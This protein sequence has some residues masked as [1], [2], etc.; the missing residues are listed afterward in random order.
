MKR[1]RFEGIKP[2]GTDV[3]LFA[4][5]F[6]WTFW[7]NCICLQSQEQW[8]ETLVASQSAGPCDSKVHSRNSILASFTE[9]FVH[10]MHF[11]A[12]PP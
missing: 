3:R 11:K 10:R 5:R 6:K 12:L 4:L 1:I 2:G 9:I 8:M 7:T